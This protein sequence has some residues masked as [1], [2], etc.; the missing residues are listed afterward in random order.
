VVPKQFT[1][2]VIQLKD[3]RILT[4]VIVGETDE[5]QLIQTEKEQI[6]ISRS[7]IEESRNT[8]KSLM[9]DGQLDTLTPQQVRDLLGFV[10]Y[11]R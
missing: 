11:R 3:G 6:S 5:T 8:G 10:M 1:T 2:S 4:G 7:E 9:P